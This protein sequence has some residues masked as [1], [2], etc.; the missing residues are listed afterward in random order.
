MTKRLN[1]TTASG[2]TPSS[3][4][5][6]RA[7]LAAEWIPPADKSTRGHQTTSKGSFAMWSMISLVASSA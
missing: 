1:A 2:E 3:L 5:V 4:G 7:R 6:P